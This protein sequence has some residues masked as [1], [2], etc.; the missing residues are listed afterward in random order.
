MCYYIIMIYYLIFLESTNTHTQLLNITYNMIIIL[1]VYQF[2]RVY[3]ILNNLQIY[4]YIVRYIFLYRLYFFVFLFLF[5]NFP[6]TIGMVYH[7]PYLLLC[8]SILYIVFVNQY[9][10]KNINKV[11]TLSVYSIILSM[12][13]NFNSSKIFYNFKISIQI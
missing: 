12:I 4:F 7:M 11:L 5:Q 3:N 8:L 10:I 9:I 13:C 2:N 1:I 6:I